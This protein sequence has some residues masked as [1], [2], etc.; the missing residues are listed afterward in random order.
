MALL[1]AAANIADR[2]RLK[3]NIADDKAAVGLKVIQEAARAEKETSEVKAAR[4]AAAANAK[5]KRG[6]RETIK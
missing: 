4:F 5:Q 6:K 1:E 2:A 3:Q